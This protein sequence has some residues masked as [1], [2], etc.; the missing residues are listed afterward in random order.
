MSHCERSLKISLIC[1]WDCKEFE[2]IVS[3]L[4]T[5]DIENQ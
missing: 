5:K 3:H 1:L 4:F 2:S